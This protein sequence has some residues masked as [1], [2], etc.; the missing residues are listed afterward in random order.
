[1]NLF[2]N[3]A[4]KK[5]FKSFFEAKGRTIEICTSC[6]KHYEKINEVRDICHRCTRM[7]NKLINHVKKHGTDICDY[8]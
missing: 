7:F 3:K 5:G 8:Y 2:K 6:R 1:M 4:D